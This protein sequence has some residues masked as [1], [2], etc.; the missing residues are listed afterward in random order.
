MKP[1]TA[2]GSHH[3]TAAIGWLELGN[4]LEAKEELERI[5]PE[6]HAH[7]DVLEVRWGICYA[8]KDFRGCYDIGAALVNQAPDRP[9]GWL[10][11]SAGLHWLNRS[12]EAY[13]L[14][15]PALGRFPDAWAIHYDMACYACVLGN[16]SEARTLLKKAFQLGENTSFR[17]TLKGALTQPK[18]VKQLALEDPDLAGLQM[19][20]DEI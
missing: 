19:A 16:L 3:L 10:H 11:R 7:P 17:Q 2:P 18:T 8:A 12:R 1:L 14:L 4:P 6:F 20:A 9:S 13:D 15:Q 5:A